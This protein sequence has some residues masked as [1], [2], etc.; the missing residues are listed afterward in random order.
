[1]RTNLALGKFTHAFLQLQ[2]LVI[3]LEIQGFLRRIA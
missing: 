3:E 1:M 2:L